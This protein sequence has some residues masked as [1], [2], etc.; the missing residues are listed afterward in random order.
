MSPRNAERDLR[1]REERVQLIL[2]AAI[3]V[4]S[5]KGFGAASISDI[6]KAAGISIGTMYHYF[7]SKDEIFA[8]VLK[9]GQLDY[10][11]RAA[12]LAD[13][14]TMPPLVK[15]HEFAAGWLANPINWAYTIMLQSARTTETVPAEIRQ[16]VTDRFTANLQPIA[17]IMKDGQGR[18]DIIAGDP[19]QLAFYYVSLIQGLTLQRAPGF[20]IPVSIDADALIRFF[21]A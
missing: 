12:E 9:R 1:V 18:G 4:I 2:D 7:S 21:E 19:L 8:D 14:Q 11:K 13:E 20:E 6:A 16:A 3:T 10:G 15:L 5:S 17:R